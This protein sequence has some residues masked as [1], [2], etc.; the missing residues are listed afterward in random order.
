MSAT[1][2]SP[3]ADLDRMW[4]R[5]AVFWH[6]IFGVIWLT[7]LLVIATD[8]GPHGVWPE[9]CCLVIVGLA[10]V[11]IG[12]GAMRTRDL[13]R[14]CAYLV[15]AWVPLGVIQ[16]LNYGTATWIFFF[17]LFPHIWVILTRRLAVIATFVATLFMAA[18]QW[19]ASDRTGSAVTSVLVGAV[20]AVTLS[21]GLGL[22]IGALVDE[23]MTRA[24]TIDR[25]TAAQEQLAASE[26]DRGVLQERE[27]LSQEIHDTLAQGFTSVLTLTRATRSALGREDLATALRHLEL[28]E[29]TAADNLREARLMVA[30]LT[31]GHLQSRSLVEALER[32]AATMSNETG[33][34]VGVTVRGTPTVQGGNTDVVQL[35]A[36]QEALSNVRKHS[37]ASRVQM[38]LTYDGEVTLTVADDGCGFEPVGEHAGFGLDGL[39][40]RA[41]AMGGTVEV[42]SAV[43]HGTR[44]TVRLPDSAAALGATAEVGE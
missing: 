10:Y 24:H 27:R 4:D 23:G 5:Q 34:P 33:V 12:R 3:A 32:L 19:F 21:L 44:V 20:I 15:C 8:P 18:A 7:S 25:L 13:A 22:F 40:G 43:G 2:Q 28:I 37:G 1:G 29:S 38:T 31:P 30:E 26:R 35:R 39:R 11:V 9:A 17:V 14:G 16:L 36:A 41:E 6:V 42:D